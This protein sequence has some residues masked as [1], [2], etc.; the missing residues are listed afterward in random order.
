MSIALN[1]RVLLP[2]FLLA[3][4]TQCGPT[5]SQEQVQATAQM[6]VDTVEITSA[7]FERENSP[8]LANWAVFEAGR[9]IISLPSGW[10][11]HLEDNGNELVLLPPDTPDSTERV[12]LTRVTKGNPAMGYLALARRQATAAF[13]RFGAVESDTLKQLVFPQDFAVERTVN[14]RAQGRAF[15]GYCLVYVDDKNLYQFRIILAKS[16][17]QAYSGSL[18][19]DII[20]NLQIDHHYFVEHLNQLKQIIYLH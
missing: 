4:C 19:S 16:R 10:N 2:L 3:T 8:A 17:L 14:F 20:G 11:G 6:P 15:R 12:T 7:H 1:A 13:A 18:F 9:E 5:V